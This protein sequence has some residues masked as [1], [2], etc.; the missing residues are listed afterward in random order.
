MYAS[1][2]PYLKSLSFDWQLVKS[3]PRCA[4][5]LN[6]VLR[7][8]VNMP[9]ARNAVRILLWY[10][11]VAWQRLDRLYHAKTPLQIQALVGVNHV[12]Y[13]DLRFSLVDT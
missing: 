1:A 5:D 11:F 6:I 13:A 9:I 2:V 4:P 12:V 10:S 3:P 7:P 8:L